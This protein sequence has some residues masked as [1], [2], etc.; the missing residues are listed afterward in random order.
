MDGWSALNIKS[1]SLFIISPRYEFQITLIRDS[2]LT[3][4]PHHDSAVVVNVYRD[5]KLNLRCSKFSVYSV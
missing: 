3:V 5:L 1:I 4:N 2:V